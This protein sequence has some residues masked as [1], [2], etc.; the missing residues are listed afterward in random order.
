MRVFVA[1]IC[2][3]M[4]SVSSHSAMTS[5]VLVVRTVVVKAPCKETKGSPYL[6]DL[7]RLGGNESERLRAGRRMAAMKDSMD[8]EISFMVGR[9]FVSLDT[10]FCIMSRRNGGVSFRS[11]VVGWGRAGESRG[12][13][14]AIHHG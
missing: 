6:S 1:K 10:Q 5:S 12:R 7:T 2:M 11:S 8:F 14:S 9:S 3:Q 4:F 13:S